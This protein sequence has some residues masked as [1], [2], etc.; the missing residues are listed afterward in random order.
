MSH[1]FSIN[2]YHFYSPCIGSS[3]GQWINLW[4]LISRA[5][6]GISQNLPNWYHNPWGTR[7]TLLRLSFQAKTPSVLPKCRGSIKIGKYL[8]RPPVLIP[9]RENKT[10]TNFWANFEASFIKYR[11]EGW[12]LARFIPGIPTEWPRITLVGCLERQN[13]QGY[14][15]HTFPKLRVITHS[16]LLIQSEVSTHPDILPAY[17][18]LL[19]LEQIL[20]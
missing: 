4:H 14:V 20:Y 15:L 7:K 2:P 6:Q 19:R 16:V 11:P 13:P 1:C 9:L 5:D 8:Y 18:P 17:R 3:I 12:T 10:T